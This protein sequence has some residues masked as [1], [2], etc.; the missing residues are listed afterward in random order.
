MAVVCECDLQSIDFMGGEG[1]VLFN[2]RQ[3]TTPPTPSEQHSV[4]SGMCQYIG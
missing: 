1:G 4:E 3:L 2:Q